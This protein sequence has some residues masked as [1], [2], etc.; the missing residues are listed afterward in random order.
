MTRR[1]RAGAPPQHPGPERQISR[2]ETADQQQS[3]QPDRQFPEGREGEQYVLDFD[4][5][6]ASDD[7]LAG[8]DQPSATLTT[9]G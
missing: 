2:R 7:V 1:R 3:R 6:P 8:R 9:G 5:L 4:A